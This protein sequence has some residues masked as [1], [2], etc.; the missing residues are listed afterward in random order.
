MARLSD[1]VRALV[2]PHLADI[3]P[4]DPNFT[5]CRINLSANENTYPVPDG[6]R[7]RVDT[8]LASTPLNRYPDPMSHALRAEIAARHGVAPACVCVGNGGDELLY[9]FLLAFGGRASQLL[10]CPP[11]FSEYEFFASLTQTPIRPRGPRSAHVRAGRGGGAGIGAL[12]EARGGR[13]HQQ[14]D[15]RSRSAALRGAPVP[16]LPRPGD[17]GRGLYRVRG[18]GRL[19]RPGCST[20][21]PTWSCCARCPRRSA[22]RGSVA[23]TCWRLPM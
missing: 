21:I 12:V 1:R 8:A 7:E 15:G 18:R 23:A 19:G 2:Q 3:E 10:V 6:V 9:N 14:P 5:P 4:Y 13:L 11:C 20:A 16:R 17:G 22:P